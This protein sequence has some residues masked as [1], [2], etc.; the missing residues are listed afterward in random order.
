MFHAMSLG[1]DTGP[2][3]RRLADLQPR[4]M[5]LMHGSSFEGDCAAALRG[6]A[7]HYASRAAAAG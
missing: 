2:V 5:A 1:P 4:A 3:L 6:L 7:E